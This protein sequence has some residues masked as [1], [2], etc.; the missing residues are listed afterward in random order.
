MHHPEQVPPARPDIVGRGRLHMALHS[1]L[2][3]TRLCPPTLCLAS[4]HQ[5][6]HWGYTDPQKFEKPWNSSFPWYNVAVTSVDALTIVAQLSELVRI[7][8]VTFLIADKAIS[9]LGHVYTCS[10]SGG[11]GV[12]L[13]EP[14]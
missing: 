3:A 2:R 8:F 4:S 1:V 7:F 12:P 10:K 13:Q 11:G 6:G 14:L 5:S 9:L